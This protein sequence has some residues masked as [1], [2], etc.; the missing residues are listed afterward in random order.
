MKGGPS[1]ILIS[2]TSYTSRQFLIE[3]VCTKNGQILVAIA[4]DVALPPVNL[5]TVYVTNGS[6]AECRPTAASIY[7]VLFQFALTECGTTQRVGVGVGVMTGA[8]AGTDDG[9]YRSWYVAID[10]PIVSVLRDPVFVEVRVL[11]RNDPTLVLVL[12]DCSATPGPEPYSGLCWDLL[13][14]RCPFVGDNY[15]TRLVP[16]SAASHLRFPTHHQRF[17]V[18][19]FTFWDRVSARALCGEGS[20]TASLMDN[21]TSVRGG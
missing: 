17:V 14:N 4:K 20:A 5:S 18:S 9:R 3:S 7:V 16:V 2:V 21:V 11:N 10:Y 19:S 13:V 1:F 12:D 8:R 15:K 6:G